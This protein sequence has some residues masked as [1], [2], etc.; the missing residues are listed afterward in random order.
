MRLMA[1]QQTG[2][3]VFH[4]TRIHLNELTPQQAHNHDG[5]NQIP[6]GKPAVFASNVADYAIFMAI[7]NKENCPDGYLAGAEVVK[8]QLTFNAT[9]KTLDQLQESAGGWVYVFNKADFN[10]RYA[11]GVEYLSNSSVIPVTKIRVT[12][13]DLPNIGIRTI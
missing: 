2:I 3:Y 12:R 13:N 1:L 5:V 8:G 9:Q 7:I 6:D 11:E 4:G 10:K